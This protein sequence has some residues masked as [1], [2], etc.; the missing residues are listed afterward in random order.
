MNPNY[1]HAFL[2][3]GVAKGANGDPKGAIN[4]FS[5]AISINPLYAKAWRNRGITKEMFGDIK[6]ACIDWKR[7]A[8]LGIEDCQDWVK[9]QCSAQ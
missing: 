3:R 7:A 2:N 6:G 9:S 1:D 5:T 8:N 4:D